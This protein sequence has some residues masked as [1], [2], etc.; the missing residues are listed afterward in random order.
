M[1]RLRHATLA[2]VLCSFILLQGCDFRQEAIALS[3]WT[4]DFSRNEAPYPLYVWNL[5]KTI[6]ELTVGV[7]PGESWI[8]VSEGEIASR[9]PADPEKGPFDK[10]V[11]II[12]IDRSKLDKG[13]HK[14]E[15]KFT[16][17]GVREKTVEVRVVMDQD[18]R[19]DTLNVVNPVAAYSSPY[20]I[21]FSFGLKDARGAALVA[22][23]AQFKIEAL[24]DDNPVKSDSGL[25][26]RRGTARQLKMDIVLDYSI[27]MQETPGAIQG[28]EETAKNVLLPALNLEA[29][30]GV[31]EFHRDDRDAGNVADFTLDRGYVR[32]RIEAVQPDYVQGFY[33]GA[34]IYDAIVAS[35]KKFDDGE[36]L[37]ESRHIVLFTVGADTSSVYSLDDA[38]RAAT[39]RG[40]H[41][42]VVGFGDDTTLPMLLDLTSR[43][44]GEFFP[45]KNMQDIPA[46]IQ[47]VIENLEGQYIL[48]WASLNRSVD[49]FLPSFSLAL[50]EGRAVFTPKDRFKPSDHRGNVLEG[51]LRLVTSSNALNS[52][53]VLRADYVPRFVRQIRL[54]VM[55]R[56][57]FEAGLV[58]PADN[59]ILGGW[60]LETV[61]DEDSGGFWLNMTT[62]QGPAQFAAFG[63][64]VR[65]DFPYPPPED[66][67]LFEEMYT[68]NSVYDGGIGFTIE[69]FD[70][71]DG[72]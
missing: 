25:Q 24:E 43:T 4:V 69:G 15:I 19:M 39:Q 7:K 55:S 47:Q 22:E 40:V 35:A 5:N 14:G 45:V 52:S 20:L 59:G 6:P 32:G 18:G 66:K 68:D 65:F 21:D 10:K 67:P 30:A 38:V 12:R 26:L 27:R 57:D 23:P 50:G 44:G 1:N 62:T 9:A 48:R 64:L 33:S 3:N 71:P 60:T 2:G 46:T 54:Y 13:E 11:V 58:E 31:T 17:K 28:M 42:L 37:Q 72:K 56:M 16:S 41:V 53:I 61:P 29:L 49:A 34:R 63:P 8:H 51:R 70:N 36:P